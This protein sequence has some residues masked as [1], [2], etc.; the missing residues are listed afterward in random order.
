MKFLSGPYFT[1]RHVESARNFRARLHY[2]RVCDQEWP[3]FYLE[4]PGNSHVKFINASLSNKLLKFVWQKM[5]MFPLKDKKF[6]YWHASWLFVLI[7]SFFPTLISLT[8]TKF[9]GVS[10]KPQERLTIDPHKLLNYHKLTHSLRFWTCLGNSCFL[11]IFSYFW[12][13]C[14]VWFLKSKFSSSFI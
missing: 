1:P 9:V 5:M 10:R 8:S 12:K 13:I 4:F 14:L 11:I 6:D 3:F 2:Q 7:W